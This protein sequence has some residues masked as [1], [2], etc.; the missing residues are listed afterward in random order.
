MPSLCGENASH[1]RCVRMDAMTAFENR[2]ATTN[3]PK[4]ASAVR[5]FVMFLVRMHVVLFVVTLPFMGG[6]WL[7][8]G[9]W[10]KAPAGGTGAPLPLYVLLA[11]PFFFAYLFSAIVAGLA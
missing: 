10:P 7:R 11:F 5:E 9:N 1:F 3:A 6:M 4:A 8:V 2:S